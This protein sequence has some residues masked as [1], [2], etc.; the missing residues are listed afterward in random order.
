[1][2]EMIFLSEHGAELAYYLG[3]PEH[4]TVANK[5]AQMPIHQQV[6]ELG[7]LE[8]EIILSQKIKQKTSA[9]PPIKP[10]GSGAGEL[11]KD[12][13]KM[14]DEEWFAWDRQQRLEKLKKTKA[15]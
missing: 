11:K 4:K 2:R 6:Y 8:K 3:L 13:S 7:G 12:P 9:P 1:M 15:V 10:V 5:I 14:T